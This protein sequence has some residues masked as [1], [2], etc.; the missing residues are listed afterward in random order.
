MISPTNSLGLQDDTAFPEQTREFLYF[1]YLQLL[2]LTHSLVDLVT[3][4]QAEDSSLRMQRLENLVEMLQTKVLSLTDEMSTIKGSPTTPRM[5]AATP[6]PLARHSDI[7]SPPPPMFF[8]TPPARTAGFVTSSPK[9]ETQPQSL[10][11][12][13]TYS[14]RLASPPSN[15]ATVSMMATPLTS[16]PSSRVPYPKSPEMERPPVSPIVSAPVR[17][18]PE[19]K[20]SPRRR[21]QR[22]ATAIPPPEVTYGGG[23]TFGDVCSLGQESSDG[24]NNA[25]RRLS[26]PAPS[27]LS[28]PLRV[29]CSH[30]EASPPPAPVTLNLE[31][32]ARANV[33]IPHSPPPFRSTSPA[34]PQGETTRT[35]SK[36]LHLGKMARP[37]RARKRQ[38]DSV[39]NGANASSPANKVSPVIVPPPCYLQDAPEVLVMPE[40]PTLPRLQESS[41]NKLPSF[42]PAPL[43]DFP[44]TTQDRQP[45]VPAPLFHFPETAQ[46]RQ[47][48][49]SPPSPPSPVPSAPFQYDGRPYQFSPWR[50][51]YSGVAPRPVTSLPP[52]GPRSSFPTLT[53][54]YEAVPPPL[55]FLH[56]PGMRGAASQAPYQHRRSR[57]RGTVR[58]GAAPP[59][60]VLAPAPL[61]PVTRYPVPNGATG[62]GPTA[63]AYVPHIS[64]YNAPSVTRPP[65][66]YVNAP[67]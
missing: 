66:S 56:S 65:Y 29:A 16:A 34:A 43:F 39:N 26:S 10:A 62:M 54:A 53:P 35:P 12:L 13:G 25:D 17:D 11:P 48:I 37:R 52:I 32:P 15:Q 5:H 42:V 1:N 60:S 14:D 22:T 36:P 30:F 44:E 3:L 6:P 24:N 64:P 49:L 45:F 8:Y 33:V 58:N 38:L 31:Q 46:D 40:P 19:L 28:L 4:R 2:C 61:G 7:S 47:P 21:R 41:L 57:P 50:P 9:S 55:P 59:I 51:G 27:P 20:P 67:A 23:M 18:M 63:R